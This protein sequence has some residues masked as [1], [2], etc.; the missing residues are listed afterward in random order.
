MS[1]HKTPPEKTD[2]VWDLVRSSGLQQPSGSFVDDVLREAR[3]SPRQRSAWFQKSWLIG[4]LTAA[5][6]CLVIAFAF[7]RSPAA[8][9]PNVVSNDLEEVSPLAE[10]EDEVEMELLFAALDYPDSISDEEFVELLY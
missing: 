8:P 9:L 1:E 7:F 10:I 4:S 5:A 3:Q 2:P 6:A